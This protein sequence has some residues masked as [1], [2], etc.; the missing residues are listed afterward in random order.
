LLLSLLL[1]V[2]PTLMLLVLC[3]GRRCCAIAVSPLLL[4]CCQAPAVAAVTTAVLL[5]PLLPAQCE[6]GG[7]ECYWGSSEHEAQYQQLHNIH[8]PFMRALQLGR[9]CPPD[10]VYEKDDGVSADIIGWG[11]LASLC[12]VRHAGMQARMHA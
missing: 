2:L 6:C 8:V 11:I 1:Y 5:P 3:Q 4:R 9:R 7:N 12:T 10:G